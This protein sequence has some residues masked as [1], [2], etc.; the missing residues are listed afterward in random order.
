M[1]LL[2]KVNLDLRPRLLDELKPG[3]PVV[4]HAFNMGEWKPDEHVTIGFRHVFLWIVPA[5]VAGRWLVEDGAERFG[6]TLEQDYQYLKGKA[7]IGGRTVDVSDGRLNGADISFTLANGRKYQ[8][9]VSGDR[10]QALPQGSG[11]TAAG[12]QAK[13]AS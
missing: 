4:S 12:W 10:M 11:G 1:Y 8:G 3:T 2:T 7:E 5:K 13:R 9:R 6:L